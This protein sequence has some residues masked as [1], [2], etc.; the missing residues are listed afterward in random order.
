M[1]NLC[2]S[3]PLYAPKAYFS[4]QKLPHLI[5]NCS[6]VTPGA[7]AKALR[8]VNYISGDRRE[9]TLKHTNNKITLIA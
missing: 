6:K 4:E 8:R 9:T 7:L 2:Q 3:E 1:E 5:L